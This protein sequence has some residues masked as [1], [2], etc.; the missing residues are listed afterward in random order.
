MAKLKYLAIVASSL[1]KMLMLMLF[2][3]PIPLYD[4]AIIK[5]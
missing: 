1:Q 2:A 5:F 4:R 3:Y